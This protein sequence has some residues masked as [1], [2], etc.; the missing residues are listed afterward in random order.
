MTTTTGG[1]RAGVRVRDTGIGIGPADATQMF[2]PFV[3]AESSLARAQ[4]GLGLGLALVR[5]L[6][7]LHGG[8]VSAHSEGRG[9]GAE[10][11]VS[12]PLAGDAA[13]RDP[14]GRGAGPAAPLRILVVDDNADA[15]Q[16]LADLLELR[17]HRVWQA[18]DGR[19]GISRA[20]ELRPDVVL[21]DLGLPDVDGYEVARAVRG[22]PALAGVL[23]VALS[24]YA[25]AE[26]RELSRAAGFV[27]HLAKPPR[28]DLLDEVF[29]SVAPLR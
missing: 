18:L 25:Q 2:E 19:T 14:T 26:H 17:G 9:R 27:A 29:A 21:C 4:G 22:D 13:T 5:G 7:E 3:Q 24:G 20:R 23:L 1:G 12:L 6:V 15:A 28:L 8:W 11:T 16:S 10:F